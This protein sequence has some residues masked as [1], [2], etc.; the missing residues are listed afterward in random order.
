MYTCKMHKF[1]YFPLLILLT[2]TLPI[3][4]IQNQIQNP[5]ILFNS[6]RP[7]CQLGSIN[8]NNHNITSPI[9]RQQSVAIKYAIRILSSYFSCQNASCPDSTFSFNYITGP[10]DDT[11]IT[12][13]AT[14]N[15][16]N[17]YLNNINSIELLISTTIHE[18]LHVLAFN[19]NDNNVEYPSWNT[20]IDNSTSLYYCKNT[21]A[22]FNR[23]FPYKE[24]DTHLITDNTHWNWN[25]SSDLMTPTIHKSSL[26]V[27]TLSVIPETR[28][29]WNQLYACLSDSDCIQYNSDSN[30]QNLNL[31]LKCIS[32]DLPSIYKESTLFSLPKICSSPIEDNT[33]IQNTIKTYNI[34]AAIIFSIVLCVIITRCNAERKSN[35]NVFEK[36]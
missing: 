5:S 20:C 4:T 16:I 19:N 9:S 34:V 26:S 18:V 36:W 33:G 21:I 27:T 35:N 6:Y 22:F 28:S 11:K 17:L 15:T 29:E 23:E 14:K 10:S 2:L 31:N 30:S 12:G 32:Y 24:S 7:F 3:F 8:F 25:W 1:H 13:F